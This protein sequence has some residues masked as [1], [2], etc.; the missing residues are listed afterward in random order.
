[1]SRPELKILAY[2]EPFTKAELQELQKSFEDLYNVELHEIT[3]QGDL[4][5]LDLGFVFSGF[6][7]GTVVKPF[8]EGS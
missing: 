2:P 5:G 6:V 7:V 8:V 4:F 1:M 3:E